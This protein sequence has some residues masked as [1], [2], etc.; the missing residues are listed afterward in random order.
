MSSQ[1]T[2]GVSV[3][4]RSR[5]SG[6]SDANYNIRLARTLDR[7]QSVQLTSFQVQDTR[8]AFDATS[9]LQVSEPLVMP[10]H[11]VVRVYEYT[12]VFYKASHQSSTHQRVLTLEL[13]PTMNPIT[14]IDAALNITTQFPHGLTFAMQYYPEIGERTGVVGGHFPHDAQAFTSAH[15]P[16]ASDGPVCTHDT[17]RVLDA[18]TFHFDDQYLHELTGGTAT[19]NVVERFIKPSEYTSYLY[20]PPP[21]LVELF[22]MLNAAVRELQLPITFGFDNEQSKL[23]ITAPERVADAVD[24]RTTVRLRVDMPRLGI[25]QASLPFITNPPTY[26]VKLK[27]GTFSGTAVAAETTWRLNPATFLIEDAAQRTLHYSL[28]AGIPAHVVILYGCYTVTQLVDY[29]NYYLQPPP[30]EIMVVYDAAR[31]VFTFTHLRGCAFALDFTA[32]TLIPRRFGFDAIAYTGASTY[33]STRPAAI[34][35]DWPVNLYQVRADESTQKY[36]FAAEALPPFYVHEGTTAVAI[37]ASWKPVVFDGEAYAHRLRVG[38]V[39]SVRRPR[40]GSTA[41]GAKRIVDVADSTPIVITTAAAHELMSGDTITIQRITGNTNANGTWTVTVLTP[42]TFELD[43]SRSNGPAT[44]TAGMWWTDVVAN[45]PTVSSHVVVGA[46]WNAFAATSSLTLLPTASMFANIPED[47]PYF[48]R[49]PLGTPASTDGLILATPRS[50]NV[51]MLHLPHPGDVPARFG[52]PSVAWPPVSSTILDA[53]AARFTRVP[54][55]AMYTSPLSWNVSP[56][57]YIIVVTK[58]HNASSEQQSHSFRGTSFPIFAKLLMS[59]SYVNISEDMNYNHFS[60]LQR[61]HSFVVEFQNPDGTRVDFN[62]R[63]HN[64][65]MLFTMLQDKSQ[66]VCV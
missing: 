58:A 55:A 48:N 44:S 24:T 53:T 21:T 12:T 11:S 32:N 22:V 37:G 62:G 40:F 25:H 34:H 52:F 66:L 16:R 41:T 7:V 45:M 5:H 33:T 60:V 42:T 28:P 64:L 51:F 54:V 56:P 65:M 8:P 36:T 3:D 13:P 19:A 27:K 43:N 18:H 57:P 35:G 38:D 59:N 6:E 50:R 17:V 15:Y 23:C 9:E 14:S 30:A 20:C 31:A 26:T 61:F 29:L 63:P 46:S 47:V 10:A 2:Y 4:V 49:Q 1:A 39:L